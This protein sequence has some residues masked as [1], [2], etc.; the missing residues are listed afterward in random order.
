MQPVNMHDAKTHLSR[1]VEAA[2]V[3]QSSIIARAGR[4]LV[5]VMPLE[6]GEATGCRTGS[7]V[8]RVPDD[9]DAI[10]GDAIAKAFGGGE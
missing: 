9:F 4:P 6:A 5:K 8:G 2:A 1:L 7:L 3:G 10:G